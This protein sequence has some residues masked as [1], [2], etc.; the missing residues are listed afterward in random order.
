MA[1]NFGNVISPE[2][3]NICPLGMNYSIK[4]VD[5]FR[6]VPSCYK[7]GLL[8]KVFHFDVKDH[9]ASYLLVADWGRHAIWQYL[10]CNLNIL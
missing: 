3:E 1:A 4:E 10:E 6:L 5:S 9:V 2:F 8:P 7:S